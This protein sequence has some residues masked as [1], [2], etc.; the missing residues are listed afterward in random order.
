MDKKARLL[1]SVLLLFFCLLLLL[2][3][4]SDSPLPEA[5]P[6]SL[7]LQGLREVHVYADGRQLSAPGLSDADTGR[8]YA[9]AAAF[10]DA[11]DPDFWAG[12]KAAMTYRTLSFSGA[13]YLCIE[14]FC[15][16]YGISVRWD[17]QDL[18][19]W[20]TSAA[21]EWSVPEGYSV[22]VLMYHGVGD[23]L[24]PGTELVV[25]TGTLE[26]Q[27]QLLLD[28]GYT[29]IWFEDLKHVDRIQKPVLLTFDDGY[30]DNY[31]ELYPLLQRYHVKATLFVVSG[32]MDNEHT[33]SREQ[34]LEMLDSGLVSIQCHTWYHQDLDTLS[35][36]EQV[37]ELC[38]SK[39]SLLELTNREP[40]VI[41]YP[42]GRQ[43]D[44]TLAIC[45]SEYRFGV[46]M[47]GPLYVTGDDPLLIHRISVPRSMT[48]EEFGAKL[49]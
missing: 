2:S 6:A 37:E 40:Y 45:R 1:R 7:T 3:T 16:D 26:S 12:E 29:P 46:K 24:R 11:L 27:L 5:A 48:L 39:I 18:R 42:R 14:D 47:G 22:P 9:P 8:H 17:E 49:P 10:L 4:G 20:C 28:R 33:V 35:Y 44:E 30:L 15:A 21:G 38:W 31:T 25:R 34:V 13:D 43:N 36:D 41:A 19:V 23:D 32:F